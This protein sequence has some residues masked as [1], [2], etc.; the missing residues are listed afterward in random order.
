[1]PVRPLAVEELGT[2]EVDLTETIARLDTLLSRIDLTLSALRDALQGAGTRDLTTLETD[3]ESAVANLNTV[4]AQL[5]ITLSALRDA[6]RG[7]GNRDLTTVE[8]DL[9]TAVSHL[10]SIV[11]QLDITLSALRDSLR[12]AGAR[13]LTTLETD[14]E[15]VAASLGSRSAIAYGQVEVGTTAIALPSQTIPS[16]FHL[17]VKAL[18]TNGAAVY[19]GDSNVSTSNGFELSAGE[20]VVLRVD[21]ANVVYVVAASGTQKVCWIVEA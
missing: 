7:T 13:D 15:S 3:V 9:E 11:S 20:A 1:M 18:S 8:T 19:V 5:D 21:N 16:G 10:N 4:V 6:L 17:V 12:G 14:V 2:I